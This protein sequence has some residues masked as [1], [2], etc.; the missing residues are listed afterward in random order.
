MKKNLLRE[1]VCLDKKKGVSKKKRK[2][3]ILRK[4]MSLMMRMQKKKFWCLEILEY[5]HRAQLII[6]LE[7]MIFRFEEIVW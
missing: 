5:H 3:K 6:N 7:E 4:F 2:L 1:R